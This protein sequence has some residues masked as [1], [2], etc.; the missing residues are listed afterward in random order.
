MHESVLLVFWVV[1][2]ESRFLGLLNGFECHWA[3]IIHEKSLENFLP[4]PWVS[5]LLL[6]GLV[7]TLLCTLSPLLGFLSDSPFWHQKWL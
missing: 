7:W 6:Q 5:T 3:S 4:E 1:L 2:E